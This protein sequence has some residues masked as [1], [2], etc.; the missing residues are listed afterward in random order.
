MK[1][2]SLRRRLG[3]TALT[4]AIAAFLFRP[5]VGIALVTRG[6]TYLQRGEI[7]RARRYYDRALFFDPRSTLAAERDAF[8]GLET[9]DPKVVAHAI[10]VATNALRYTPSDLDL[11]ADRGLLLQRE[12]RYAEARTDFEFVARARRD[13]RY[14]HF[15]AWAAYRSHDVLGAR[16][17]WRQALAL[18]PG[19]TPA[20]NA[21]ARAGQP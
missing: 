2:I 5:Q 7:E 15:A 16:A 21:L 1:P 8:A 18:A 9:T 12:R 11:H 6:D 19:F 10:V 4:F 20:R 3:L 14:Y 13:F 17:L